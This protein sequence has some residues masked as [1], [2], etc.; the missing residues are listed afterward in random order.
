M[1]GI[2]GEMG[3]RTAELR[4]GFPQASFTLFLIGA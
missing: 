4:V 3:Q 2:Y 1:V